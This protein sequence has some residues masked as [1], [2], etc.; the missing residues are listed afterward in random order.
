MFLICL[1]LQDDSG[2][3]S[4]KWL[5]S[6]P[7]TTY[8]FAFSVEEAMER[9]RNLELQ[10]DIGTTCVNI[11]YKIHAELAFHL[12]EIFMTAKLLHTPADRTRTSPKEKV[13]L[14]PT[15]KGVSVLQKYVRDIGL[16]EI[17]KLLLSDFNSMDLFIFERNPANDSIIH[18]DSLVRL[19]FTKLMGPSPNVWSP[20][21]PQDKVAS[22]SK[23]LEYNNDVFSFE[24]VKYR[25]FQSKTSF[26]GI[27]GDQSD[28]ETESSFKDENRA[29]PFFHKFFTN[30][31]S[32]SHIQYY[33]SDGGLRVFKSKV[34][35]Q[36]K[37]LI[38]FC[39][40]TKAFWQWIM[41]CTDVMYPK[42]AVSVAALFL[43]AGLIVPILLPPSENC[44]KRFHVSRSSFYTLSQRGWEC[45]QWNSESGI[46]RSIDTVSSKRPDA[47]QIKVRDKEWTDRE[48]VYG[49]QSSGS[50]EE[51]LDFANNFQF[52][53]MKDVLSDPGMRYLFRRHLENDFCAENL[54]A[55]MEIQKLLKKMDLLEKALSSK[56]V[57][58]VRFPETMRASRG[59]IRATVDTAF[60]RHANECL[61]MAYHIY[62]SYIMVN[63]PYQLNIDHHL[64]ESISRIMLH[65][66]SP[67]TEKSPTI[68]NFDDDIFEDAKS[69]PMTPVESPLLDLSTHCVI[70]KSS[71]EGSAEQNIKNELGKKLNVCD[72]SVAKFSP[73]FSDSHTEC[74]IIN[75][76]SSKNASKYVKLPKI[77]EDRIFNTLNVLSKLHPKFEVVSHNL[78]HLMKIDSL[79]KFMRSNIYQ[80]ALS[81]FIEL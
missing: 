55:Y 49:V 41:D 10:V 11:S 73:N 20:T 79:Q 24:S 13:L 61:E 51:D 68:P 53:S 78:H 42:E 76:C 28:V 54:D 15:P 44:R 9:M 14:Q 67:L 80:E 47:L 36:K 33:V 50:D 39:F 25:P 3:K 31:D 66:R 27:E 56:A 19:L 18:S 29:S 8:R 65:P 35:G 43:K 30:P 1:N 81:T 23:L 22:L 75:S 77:E 7:K 71:G 64:R 2:K 63:S 17:P 45:I 57:E 70:K 69:S 60:S 52:K 40:T 6:F 32:D 12:L 5:P 62:S 26:E 4:K 46:K 59:N 38:D 21:K 74:S 58:G 16:K 48:D 34:F 72:D 37:T